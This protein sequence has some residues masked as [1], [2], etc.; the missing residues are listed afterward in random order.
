MKDP[1]DV[2]SAEQLYDDARQQRRKRSQGPTGTASK[3]KYMR[4]KTNLACNVGNIVLALQT[5]PELKGAFG[6]DE[7]M[8]TEVLLRPL[9][10]DQPNFKRRPLTDTDI[11]TVQAHLQ[12]FGFPRLGKDTAHQAIDTY[13]HENS[14]HPVRD[15]LNGLEWDGVDRLPEWLHA[16]TGAE[17]TVYTQGIGKMFLIGMVARIMRPGCKLDYLPIVE[18]ATKAC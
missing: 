18:K 6:Y 1:A 5:E 13:A 14:F 7:M 2:M 10:R 11:T 16:Y 15:Y 17:N 9:F 4:G 8:R 12:W 3:E